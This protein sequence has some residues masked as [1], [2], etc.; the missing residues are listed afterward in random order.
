MKNKYQIRKK[1]KSD[2]VLYKPIKIIYYKKNM[3]ILL[4]KLLNNNES[5]FLNS[6]FLNF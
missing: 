3:S 1:L 5:K 4:E 6:L 2:I